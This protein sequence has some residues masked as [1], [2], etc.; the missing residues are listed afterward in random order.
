LVAGERTGQLLIL[1]KGAGS[2]TKET[3]EIAKVTVPCLGKMSDKVSQEAQ[4]S[5]SLFEGRR[6][7]GN[8]SN[9]TFPSG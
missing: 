1:K 5:T 8:V 7:K 6:T 3:I 2:I 9:L 4:F